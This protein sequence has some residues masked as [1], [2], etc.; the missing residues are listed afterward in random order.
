VSDQFG[1]RTSCINA[2]NGHS[3]DLGGIIIIKITI[4]IKIKIDINIRPVGI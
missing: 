1:G 3:V 2:S 4:K